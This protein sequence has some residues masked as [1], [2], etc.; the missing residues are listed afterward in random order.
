M[1]NPTGGSRGGRGGAAAQRQSTSTPPTRT[2]GLIARKK[3]ERKVGG[4]V[5]AETG[6]QL[7]DYLDFCKEVEGAEPDMDVVVENALLALFARAKGFPAWRKDRAK[8]AKIVPDEVESAIDNLVAGGSQG[9]G[10]ARS[11]AP[12]S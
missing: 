1:A 7:D 5:S 4:K 6:E 9:G 10:S 11:G 2:T 8:L 12:A 3:E